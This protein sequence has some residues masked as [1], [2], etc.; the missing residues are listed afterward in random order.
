[1]DRQ[2]YK[3]IKSTYCTDKNL[4]GWMDIFTK[5]ETHTDGLTLQAHATSRKGQRNE[6]RQ[7]QRRTLCSTYI[8]ARTQICTSC[9]HDSHAQAKL[10]RASMC[11]LPCLCLTIFPYVIIHAY[12]IYKHASARSMQALI[13]R[14]T[15]VIAYVAVHVSSGTCL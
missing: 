8:L 11:P 12:I 4:Y 14:N 5:T 6:K 1:M 3:R 15:C 2:I 7:Q 9:I 10:R 13:I